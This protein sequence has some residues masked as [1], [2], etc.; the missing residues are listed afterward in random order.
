MSKGRRSKVL[1]IR[2]KWMKSC[3]EI[4]SSNTMPLPEPSPTLYCAR[5]MKNSLRKEIRRRR[6]P[7]EGRRSRME[8]SSVAATGIPRNLLMKVL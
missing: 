4:A 5:A 3:P 7:R 8:N 6:D 2:W 1:G